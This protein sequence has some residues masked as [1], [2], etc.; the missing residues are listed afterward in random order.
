MDYDPASGKLV[1]RVRPEHHFPNKRIANVIN[2]RQAGKIVGYPFKHKHHVY[3]KVGISGGHY[4]AHRLIW[5]M[6]NG[7]DPEEI[8]HIDGNGLNNS[9]ANLRNCTHAQNTRNARKVNGGP[10][11]KGVHRRGDKWRAE[12][13]VQNKRIKLGTFLTEEMA[14]QAYRDASL[15]LHGEFSNFGYPR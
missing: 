7:G 14:H 11:L 13:R 10:L 2:S 9:I 6:V 3:L 1:W 15:K 5:K 4:L 12:I 8:D